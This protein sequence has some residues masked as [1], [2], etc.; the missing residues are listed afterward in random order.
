VVKRHGL[1]PP[2]RYR[3]RATFKTAST[4]HVEETEPGT[5]LFPPARDKFLNLN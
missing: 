2:V 5:D 3:D 4:A 1:L